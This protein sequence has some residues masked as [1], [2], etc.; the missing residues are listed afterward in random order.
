MHCSAS[1]SCISNVNKQIESICLGYIGCVFVGVLC[2]AVFINFGWYVM[3]YWRAFWSMKNV[4]DGIELQYEFMVHDRI[5]SQQNLR[6]NWIFDLG[7]FC[8][9]ISLHTFYIQTPHI[10]YICRMSNKISPHIIWFHNEKSLSSIGLE[11]RYVLAHFDLLTVS[12]V[13]CTSSFCKTI[14]F[15]MRF[16]YII[17][18]IQQCAVFCALLANF[19]QIRKINT[20]SFHSSLLL[21]FCFTTFFFSLASLSSLSTHTM[22]CYPF[23]MF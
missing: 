4:G 10:K 2:M 3:L 5:D 12:C 19:P 20:N 14:K 13:Q 6:Y 8:H 1:C 15:N 16:R 23:L 9:I 11:I 21:F 17:I 7:H 18:I 22:T